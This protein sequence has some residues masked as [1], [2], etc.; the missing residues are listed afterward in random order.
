MY[1]SD[2][3][4]RTTGDVVLEAIGLD[5]AGKFSDVSFSLHRG[6]ILGIGGLI[7][8]GSETLALTLFGDTSPDGG[9]IRIAGID[10]RL[11]Q[12]RDAIR[13]GIGF[14]PGDRER[15]GLILNLSLERNIALPAL[16]WL[17]TGGVVRPGLERGIARRL[18][19][20]LGIIAR[21]QNDIPFNLSGGNRQKVVLSK[22]LVRDHSV[23]I[24]HNPTR[25][26]DVGGK[27]E[28]YEV[29]RKLADQGS[30]V[31]LIS[32]ELPELIG[33][34]DTL[35]IMRRGKVSARITRNEKPTEEG[36]IGYML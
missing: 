32:D 21:D 16:P 15:E 25:G 5:V 26:V 17:Q 31:I 14:V 7:G 6:E 10:T 22:W 28:I 23:L 30:G 24:L 2:A 34:S 19:A 11:R 1:R 12:P 27:A 8:C 13:H 20:E 35:L 29:I 9:S 18:I 4:A 33:M 36:L 3:E